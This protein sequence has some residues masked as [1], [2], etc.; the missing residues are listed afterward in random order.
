M[1]YELAQ[2]M[3]LIWDPDI[4]IYMESANGT[5]EKSI[6]LAKNVAFKFGDITVFLQVH[7]IDGPAYKVLLGRPFEVLTESSI[8]NKSD[9]TQVVTLTDPITEKRVSMPTLDR[10]T[11]KATV[12][13]VRDEDDPPIRTAD[14]RK[15]S[16]GFQPASRS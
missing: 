1:S 12:E 13:S 6:G 3:G 7:I 4:Q 2:K 11:K 8:K 9:G 5:L 16:E 15:P 14:S 10:G